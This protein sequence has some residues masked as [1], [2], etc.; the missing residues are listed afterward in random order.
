MSGR[1]RNINQLHY[2]LNVREVDDAIDRR[3]RRVMTADKERVVREVLLPTVG[4]SR[5]ECA[6]VGARKLVMEQRERDI[7]RQ[8]R[9]QLLVRR[10]RW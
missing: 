8:V 6:G 2:Q 7:D 5:I 10:R 9:Q 1:M 4:L 3:L